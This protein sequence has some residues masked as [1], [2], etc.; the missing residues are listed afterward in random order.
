[1]RVGK[2]V[3][4]LLVALTGLGALQAGPAAAQGADLFVETSVSTAS[5][6]VGS[7]LTY[8]HAVS[9]VAG[10]VATN[11]TL[12]DM[13]PPGTT[14]DSQ[15]SDS[16]C[17]VDTCG[18]TV[19]CALGSLGASTSVAVAVI[20]NGTGPIANVAGVA[21]NEY[22]PVMANNTSVSLL[23]VGAAA[24]CCISGTILLSGNGLLDVVVLAGGRSGR[25]NANGQYQI[26]D[27]ASGTQP[28]TPS[29]AGYT[30]SPPS[31]NVSVSGTDVTGVDFTATANKYRVRGRVTLGAGGPGLSEVKVM[32]CSSSVFTNVDGYYETPQTCTHGEVYTVDPSR[33]GYSFSPRF[34]LVIINAGDINGVNFIASPG[35][36]SISGTVMLGLV[37]LADVEVTAGSRSAITDSSG[38]YLISGLAG[39]ATYSVV[40]ARY[41]YVFTPAS[42]DVPIGGASV[43]AV[44]FS[45]ALFTVLTI[46]P[47]SGPTAGGTVVAVT[48]SGFG[49]G[50]TVTVG[51][52]PAT[53]VIF[54][55][56]TAIRATTPPHP[57]AGVVPVV[58]TN[59]GGGVATGALSFE[60]QAPAATNR[61]HPITPCRAVD[62]RNPNGPF[63]GPA[64]TAA[65][66]RNYDLRGLCGI[67]ATAQA[68]ELNFTVV[69]PN[70]EGALQIAPTG[71]PP[72]LDLIPFETGMTRAQ[73]LSVPLIG[74]TPGS[75]TVRAMPATAN[76]HLVIDVF[77]YHAP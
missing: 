73:F 5:P 18:S 61:F 32:T 11:V 75:F 46:S 14:Y 51:G 9:L 35:A 6:T 27:V 49:P 30:F 48:G 33:P 38:S 39:D 4:V 62:T 2:K 54:E 50:A 37:R 36:F 76:V 42:R 17:A 21:A 70:V 43:T 10:S 16:R 1:M 7:R 44:N 63:G 74:A 28:V 20:P 60:Y 58:V 23:D 3:L 31:R 45:A 68:L 69:G 64:F 71:I 59:P 29:L 77:G 22:D 67:P 25:T 41:G 66:P 47:T 24:L 15:G 26:C 56:P 57:L 12:T 8:T 34:E 55:S 65:T 52:V 72:S 13:L 40:P 53:N 19:T